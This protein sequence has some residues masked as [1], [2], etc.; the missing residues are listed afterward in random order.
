[1]KST[2]FLGDPSNIMEIMLRAGLCG[3]L[4][5]SGCLV[6]NVVARSSSFELEEDSNGDRG[7]QV[8]RT[9]GITTIATS[10]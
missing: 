1:M 4:W 2:I 8:F 7:Q 5:R 9:N 6:S 3:E 10:K